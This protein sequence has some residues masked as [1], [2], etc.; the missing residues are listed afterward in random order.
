MTTGCPPP[1][2]LFSFV[3]IADPHVSG[4]PVS[5]NA[6]RLADCVD[7]VNANKTE[8]KI[9]LTFVVGDIGNAAG[10]PIAKGFLDGLTVP[11]L[12]LIGDNIIQSGHEM[13]FHDIFAPQYTYLATVLENWQKAPTP[14]WNPEIEAENHF[15]NYSFDNQGLH[16]VC[17]DWATRM[18]DP[19]VEDLA[20]LHDFPGGTWT[21][22]TSDIQNC[23][24]PLK[25]NILMLSHH[26]MHVNPIIPGVE[27]ASFSSEES[28]VIET[29]TG[30]LGEYVYAN[31]PGHYHYE[32]YQWRELGQ[33]HLYVTEASHIN[34]N[35]LRLVRVY[36][37][38]VTFT[39]HH[40]KIV[41][42]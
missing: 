32:W 25:E 27:Y 29:F 9:D 33:Y 31:L 13:T 1:D 42:P 18:I 3:V 4:D 8:K 14:V 12:P 34:E 16:F 2:P 38:G 22:F 39:F 37:D 15:Q 35:S 10:L 7:W 28:T 41:M 30:G 24:K 19:E 21:W 40:E 6:L 26:P 36:N 17:L 23:I 20:D 11:Y 5:E